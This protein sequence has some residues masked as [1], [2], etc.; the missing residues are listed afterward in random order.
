MYLSIVIPA[1]NE[2]PR[3]SKTLQ[4][5]C[6]YL[7]QQPYPAEVIVVDDGSGDATADTV[8]PFCGGVPPVHLLHNGWNRGKGF[9]VRRG[10]LHA[11]GEYLLFSDADL[12]TPI[13]EVE[14]LLA[15][16]QGPCSV[17][18]GSRALPA[19][20]V[21]VSQPWYRQSMGRFFNALV[22]A[23]AVP[24]VQDTQC[25]F[26]CFRREAALAICQRMTSERFG[27]DVEMLYLARRLGY[28]I[29]E[30]PV[31]WRNSPQTRV[32]ALRDSLSMCW[33]LLRI[34][35]NDGRGRYDIHSDV[36]PGFDHSG[37]KPLRWSEPH[38]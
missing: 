24:G 11:H 21:E 10:F 23:L 25:G 26:K 36:R 8:T 34:R 20:R 18:I 37:I 33:D 38:V 19:S 35:W 15:A 12:S 16:L 17:A 5:V 14:K 1:Y 2:E 27:F 28:L 4:T 9:S 29:H 6:A 7:K 31:V 22:Q 13:E 30:V 32:H 3:I